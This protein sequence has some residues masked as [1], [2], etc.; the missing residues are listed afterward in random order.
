MHIT[1]APLTKPDYRIGH[2]YNSMPGQIR[3]DL[4]ATWCEEL[5]P[6]TWS[7]LQA[8]GM[9]EMKEGYKLFKLPGIENVDE[10]DEEDEDADILN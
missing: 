7:E 1:N 9:Q 8:C 5:Y 4:I 2:M 10:P 3:K 6:S